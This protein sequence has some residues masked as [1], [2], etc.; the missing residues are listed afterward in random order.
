MGKEA[1]EKA[2]ADFL[3]GNHE[4]VELAVGR[5]VLD[6]DIAALVEQGQNRRHRFRGCVK[7]C[8]IGLVALQVGGRDIKF[9]HHFDE[10][11]GCAR[12]KPVVVERAIAHAVE[13]TEGVE[14]VGRG[15]GEMIA[16]V[17]F[18][19]FVDGLVEGDALPLG[20]THEVVVH[21]LKDF[22]LREPADGRKLGL[23]TDIDEVVEF[24]EDAHLRKLRDAR[25]EYEAQVRVAGFQ[26]RVEVA[27]HLSQLRQVLLFV[28]HIQQRCIVFVNEHNHLLARLGVGFVN[29]SGQSIVDVEF[30]S[31]NAI[32]LLIGLQ[33]K[34]KVSLQ[35]FHRVVLTQAHIKMQHWIF[36]PILLQLLNGQPL[37]QLALSLEIC[38][39]SRGQ[40][41]LAEPS[42]TAQ[43][44]IIGFMVN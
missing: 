11:R 8:R 14:D 30:Q 33:N 21:I 1:A 39:E 26:W 43:E 20:Q 44:E 27:H 17:G 22:L 23:H 4:G 34:T 42:G 18:G 37:E 41:R 28:H 6:G 19:E 10:I 35:F 13:H 40:Q 12:G 36:H 3:I 38:L 9:P 25:Q 16:I 29:E 24:A 7:V 5:V 31:S 2:H 32:L 15:P